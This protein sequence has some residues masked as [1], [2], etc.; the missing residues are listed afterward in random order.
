MHDPLTRTALAAAMQPAT[1]TRPRSRLPEN[2]R[3]LLCAIL[4]TAVEDLKYL[5]SRGFIREGRV[6]QF[7]ATHKASAANRY[8]RGQ[9]IELVEWFTRGGCDSLLQRLGMKVDAERILRVS[10]FYAAGP[11]APA[12]VAPAHFTPASAW[13]SAASQRRKAA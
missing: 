6:V 8:T 10:G 11:A 4:E 1:P 3:T 9:A 2:L 7:D 5:I 12:P 13:T